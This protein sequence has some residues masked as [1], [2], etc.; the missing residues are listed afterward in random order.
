MKLPYVYRINGVVGNGSTEPMRA[1]LDDEDQ[2]HVIIKTK[3]NP[4]GALAIVN[5]L[6]AY[7]LAVAVDLPIP[8]SGV[9]LIDP[10]GMQKESNLITAEDFGSC[11]YSTE[12]C[13]AVILNESVVAMIENRD[14][15]E[16]ILLF[17]HLIYNKDR[18]LG[19][20]LMTTAKGPKVLYAIDHTHAFKNQTIWDAVCLHQGIDADDF[21]DEDILDGNE[22]VYSMFKSGGNITLE[23][24]RE[25]SIVFKNAITSELIDETYDKIPSDWSVPNEDLLALKEYLLYRLGHIDD[26]CEMIS[27]WMRR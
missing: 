10:T 18:N 16:K 9:A 8:V 20:A 2:T 22:E 12:I 27:N 23:S 7:E 11:F 13:N 17:D 3:N 6:I 14:A 25:S 15:F 21:L 5:E 19:N 4:Q 24:L 1:D 26:M